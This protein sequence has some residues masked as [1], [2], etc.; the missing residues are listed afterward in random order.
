MTTL[1]STALLMAGA[2]TKKEELW[3]ACKEKTC[4]QAPVVIPTGRD[5]WRIAR[6][7]DAPPWSFLRYFEIQQPRRDAFAL[8]GS[9]R[10]FR[11]ALAKGS[12][13]RKTQP[14]PCIFLMS[15]R[16]G[17]R[18]CMLGSLRPLVCRA[19]P[20][21]MADGV[22]CM[23]PDHGCTCRVWT[24]ASVDVDEETALV[25]ARQSDATEYCSV[26]AG[27]NDRMA[28]LAPG[29]YSSFPS[30]LDF[31]VEAYDGLDARSNV[32]QVP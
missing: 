5:V 2:T 9:G 1:R 29:T 7:M 27:W 19:F 32:G 15:T 4:C 25:E 26:V 22:L 23:R 21:E 14:S 18:R 16:D 31:L 11:M 13:R 10:R 30:Y 20:S 28:E 24:L 3:L 6:A 8:D 12:P 17:S